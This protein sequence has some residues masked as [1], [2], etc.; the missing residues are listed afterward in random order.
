MSALAATIIAICSAVNGTAWA[1]ASVRRAR[2]KHRFGV[3]A[4]DDVPPEQ[5]A[6]IIH[7]LGAAWPE[8]GPIVAI[9]LPHSS[10]KALE[11]PNG[12]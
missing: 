12:P 5:R 3:A 11:E 1:I 6:E 2:Y 7:A 10:R 8:R 9:A 4:L